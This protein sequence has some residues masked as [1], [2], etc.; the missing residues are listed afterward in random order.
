MEGTTVACDNCNRGL[1]PQ[2][3]AVLWYRASSGDVPGGVRYRLV[4]GCEACVESIDTGYH[5]GRRFSLRQAL[6]Q[7]S[8]DPGMHIRFSWCGRCERRVYY[9]TAVRYG[10][11]EGDTYPRA[12]YC[13][14]ACRDARSA[15][16]SHSYACEVCGGGFVARRSD[17]RTCS[18]AC[19]QRAYRARKSR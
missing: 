15:P 18:P 4:R 12:T 13:S 10:E 9:A 6:R 17:A 1:R 19:R 14:V 11:E 16:H 3:A 8:G 5:A 7:F 2:D